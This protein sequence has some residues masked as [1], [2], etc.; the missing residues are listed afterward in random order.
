MGKG[1]II[2][3]IAAGVCLLLGV[4]SVLLGVKLTGFSKQT[5]NA[6]AAN[7]DIT[8]PFEAVSV[9]SADFDISVEASADDS[10]HVVVLDKST[11]FGVRSGEHMVSVIDGRL[12]IRREKA[13]WFPMG[14]FWGKRCITLYLPEGQCETLT[15]QTASGDVVVSA[16]KLRF[17]N[18]SVTSA[19]GDLTFTGSV[20]SNLTML[21]TS[22]DV[23]VNALAENVNAETTSGDLNIHCTARY[24]AAKT[25]SGD[26]EL[27]SVGC[28]DLQVSATSGDVEFSDLRALQANIHTVSG[29]VKG[30]LKKTKYFDV[31]TTSGSVNVPHSQGADGDYKIE[32]TSGDVNIWLE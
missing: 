29:E 25:T 27:T 10:C 15:L 16:E 4:T 7:Y 19:S 12:V 13:D 18:V 3:L 31:K 22:G 26:V 1:T 21:S 2:A 6:D 11:G 20:K 9:N 32:T 14:F 28:E 17:Q 5:S 23:T 24:V 30:S 8:E